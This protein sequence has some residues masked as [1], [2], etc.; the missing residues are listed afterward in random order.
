[1]AWRSLFHI[2]VDSD[3]TAQRVLEVMQREKS[4]RITF[5]PLNRLRPK[6][7]TYPPATNDAIPL[8]KKLKYNAT[9]RA[10]MEQVRVTSHP[11]G[12]M[13]ALTQRA[14]VW[15]VPDLPRLGGGLGLFQEPQPEWRDPRRCGPSCVLIRGCR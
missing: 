5:M 15:Q 2:V 9:Y 3:E 11:T 4:G 6:P 1:V 14:G 7:V 8:I 12:W 10:A 13:E